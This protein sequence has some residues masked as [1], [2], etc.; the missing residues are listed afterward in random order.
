ME[1][2]IRASIAL[3]APLDRSDSRFE[4][5]SRHTLAHDDASRASRRNRTARRIRRP[6]VRRANA[7]ERD[8]FLIG[9][10]KSFSAFESHFHR[11]RKSPSRFTMMPA[12]RNRLFRDQ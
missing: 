10:G 1:F 6:I 7:R 4:P 8:D 3:H 5:Q 12:G 9:T 2:R 11:A